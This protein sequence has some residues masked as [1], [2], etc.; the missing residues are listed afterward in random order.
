MNEQL[1]SRLSSVR[2][3]QHRLVLLRHAAMGLLLGSVVGIC[4][5]V[6]RVQGG[7]ISPIGAILTAI[8][9]LIGG[10]LLGWFRVPAWK[11]SARAIDSHYRLKDRS[12]TA[13]AFSHNAKTT[14]LQ[15]LQVRDAIAHLERVD[16]EDVVPFRIPRLVPIAAMAFAAVAVLALIPLANR[17]IE[18]KL[19]EPL[20]KVVAE[21][22]ILE[23][24][25]LEELNELAEESNEKEIEEL[26]AELEELVQ[27]MKEEGVD[28]REALAK[29]SEMQA[30]VA[31]AQAEFN[32]DVIDAQM[33]A[34]GEA[35]APAASMRAASSALQEGDYKKAADKLENLD[36]SMITKKESKTVAQEL[37]KLSQGMA[38]AG[39]GQLSE[40]TSEYCE[41]LGSG[42]GGKSNRGAKKIA[43]LSR[44]YALRKKV[45]ECLGCQ[46]AR[47]GECKSNCNKN[48]GR[49]RNKSNRPSN[50]WGKGS[51]GNPFGD[52]ATE[53][54]STRREEQI[55]G[56]AGE[57]PSEREVT[58]S[59][60]GRETASRQQREVYKEFRKQAEEVLQSEALP[61]GHRQT[62]RQYFE[63]IRPVNGDELGETE[64]TN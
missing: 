17:Q 62:I 33:H 18:A 32:M 45:G 19:V 59:P 21:A 3:R 29:L 25:M 23:E 27:E 63:S 60:E 34:M 9:G 40:A 64:A 55:T 14:E 44:K 26:A 61:L 54:S 49:A 58:H 47:L 51:T 8:G 28:E 48:G 41:G 56:T 24:T 42:D 22:E 31:A 37:K 43:K 13:L 2:S 16:A 12:S 35:M 52:D 39:M 1:R 4:L 20:E 53:I 46:L 7:A 50:N 10:L 15:Q 57:G 38:D 11:E 5:V 30:A 36:P 6:A